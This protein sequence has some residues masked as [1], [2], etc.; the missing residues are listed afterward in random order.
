MIMHACFVVSPLAGL[1]R[2]QDQSRRVK[3]A[4]ASFRFTCKQ[5]ID[6][7]RVTKG[8][9]YVNTH[10][11]MRKKERMCVLGAVVWVVGGLCKRV[12]TQTSFGL[13]LLTC[14]PASQPPTG[15]HRC[16][17]VVQVYPNISDKQNFDSV[18]DDFKFKDEKD[19]VSAA[20]AA[21]TGRLVCSVYVGVWSSIEQ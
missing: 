5:V 2:E 3:A 14:L 20:A 9:R 21:A 19:E 18:L 17:C 1:M 12:C 16:N 6:I 4:Q 13:L 15:T 11:Y 10:A 8:W 7:S